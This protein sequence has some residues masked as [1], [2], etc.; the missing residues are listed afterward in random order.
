MKMN[1]A[2]S[3]SVITLTT[4]LFGTKTKMKAESK[5]GMKLVTPEWSVEEVPLKT[6]FLIWS[7]FPVIWLFLLQEG[8]NKV[9]SSTQ[10]LGCWFITVLTGMSSGLQWYW[11]GWGMIL[12]KR[13]IFKVLSE[14]W[15]LINVQFYNCTLILIAFSMSLMLWWTSL[16]IKLILSLR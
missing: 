1:L 13:S 16:Y 5:I 9:I 10:S 12:S 6:N 14:P 8:N 7:C 4:R 15:F 3:P 2:D 11:E